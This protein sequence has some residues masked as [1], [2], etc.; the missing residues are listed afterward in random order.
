MSSD[1]HS[2]GGVGS[3]DMLILQSN[4]IT[5]LKVFHCVLAVR[6]LHSQFLLLNAHTHRDIVVGV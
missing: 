3:L 6:Y 2:C 5:A 4:W 1:K